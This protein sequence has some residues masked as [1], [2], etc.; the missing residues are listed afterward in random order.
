M[1]L[2]RCVSSR[3]AH[4]LAKFWTFAAHTLQWYLSFTDAADAL[5]ALAN[6]ALDTT[7]N[8]K[9]ALPKERGVD[10]TRTACT[11]GIAEGTAEGAW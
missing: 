3:S 5:A 2:Y 6:A 7:R 11:E 1:V 10:G 4:H 8:S 9:N